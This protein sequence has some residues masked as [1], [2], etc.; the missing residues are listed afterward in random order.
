MWGFILGY[1][2]K[3]TLRD[4]TPDD[5]TKTSTAGDSSDLLQ[6]RIGHLSFNITL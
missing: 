1:R 6:K 3:K 2:A 5:H 4:H